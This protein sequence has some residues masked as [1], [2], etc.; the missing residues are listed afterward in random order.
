MYLIWFTEMP[1]IRQMDSSNNKFHLP[2]GYAFA[3]KDAIKPK[4]VIALR[5]ASKGGREN[6]LFFV[7]LR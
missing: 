2:D 5:T 3:Y 7:I 4:E 1:T 6:T